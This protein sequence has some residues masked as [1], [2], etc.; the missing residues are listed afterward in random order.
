MV[1]EGQT[2]VSSQASQNI[3]GIHYSAFIIHYWLHGTGTSVSKLVDE[4]T[5][6]LVM[7]VLALTTK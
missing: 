4:P 6:Y 1:N 5:W 7:R 3:S 2:H